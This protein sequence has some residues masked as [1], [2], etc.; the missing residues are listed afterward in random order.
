MKQLSHIKKSEMTFFTARF[1]DKSRSKKEALLVVV[2]LSSHCGTKKITSLQYLLLHPLLN[3]P[4]FGT[5]GRWFLPFSF[6]KK[7]PSCFFLVF[8]IAELI[9]KNFN[10][11]QLE[12]KLVSKY[13]FAKS[14]LYS[15]VTKKRRFQVFFFLFRQIVVSNY[16]T[17]N[18]RNIQR[19]LL[20]LRRVKIYENR[21]RRQ[22][23]LS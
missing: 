3:W 13:Y 8:A 20:Y 22:I 7:L 15:R 23:P 17:T 19:R 10:G 1:S 21:T 4:R 6:G 16:S 11:K 9:L 2:F 5:S 18:F 14:R 12:R